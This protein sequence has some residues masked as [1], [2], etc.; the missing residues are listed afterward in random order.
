MRKAFDSEWTHDSTLSHTHV[1]LHPDV[2]HLMVVQ[3][4]HHGDE[5][6]QHHHRLDGLN[7]PGRA[8]AEELQGHADGLWHR[9]RNT[10]SERPI[11]ARVRPNEMSARDGT[12]PNSP[13][14]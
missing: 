8:E 4:E 13:I 6:V 10:T 12:V 7:G 2:H 11:R 14:Q 5:H 3:R 9:G 1:W